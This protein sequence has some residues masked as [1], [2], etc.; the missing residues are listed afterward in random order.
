MDKQEHGSRLAA[1]MAGKGDLREVVADATGR[2]VRTVTNWTRGK[3]MP[4]AIERGVLR[5]L[6]PGYDEPGDPVEVAIMHSELTDDRRHTVIGAYKRLLR[7]QATE[8]DQATA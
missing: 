7:E 8:D 1:A 6:Y 3:T 2:D 4:S 5:R